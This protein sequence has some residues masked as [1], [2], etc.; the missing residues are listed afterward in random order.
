LCV[1]DNN[2]PNNIN[3][4]E[5]KPDGD[6]CRVCGG[7]LKKR[8]DDQDGEAIDQR[9]N[10]YYNTE[11][12]TRSA[13]QYFKDLSRQNGIPAIVELDGR[14]NVEAVSNELMGKLDLLK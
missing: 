14:N 6:R 5:I 3:I 7:E 2:H 10:I 8:D 1:N 9:H 4:D 13:V 12:G 11:T